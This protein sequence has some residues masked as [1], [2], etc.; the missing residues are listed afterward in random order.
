L[1]QIPHL[2]TLLRVA[3]SPVLVWLIVKSSF[4]AALCIVVLAGVTDWLDG[5]AARKLGVM[6]KL[7]T[8]LDPMAD[9]LMLVTLFFALAYVRLIPLWL[10]VLVMGRDVVIVTG[11]LLVRIFRNIRKFTPSTIGKVSTFFQIVFVLMVLLYA[12]V[13][14]GFFH[15]LEVL[16]LIL[17]TLFTTLSGAGYIRLGIRMARRQVV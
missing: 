12:A 5:Y 2:L 8:I 17:T 11:A 16:A 13:P 6:G 7:G 9:K 1:R 15:L 3:L 10:L 4:D 14:F